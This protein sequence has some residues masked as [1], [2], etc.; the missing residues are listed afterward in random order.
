MPPS[1][2]SE[3]RRFT[4]ERVKED[5]EVKEVYRRCSVVVPPVTGM[6]HTRRASSHDFGRRLSVGHYSSGMSGFRLPYSPAKA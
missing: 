6:G 3:I 1:P 2:D 4:F 5:E